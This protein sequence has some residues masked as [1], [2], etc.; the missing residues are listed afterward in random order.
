MEDEKVQRLVDF[1]LYHEMLHKKH[2]Y[3][4]KKQRAIHHSKAFREDEAKW[5]EKDME[6]KLSWFLS[7]KRIKKLLWDW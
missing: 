1:V 7:K 5:H 2:Q 6:K 4:H 3:D